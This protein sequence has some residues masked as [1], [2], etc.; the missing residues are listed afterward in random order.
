ME[1][2]TGMPTTKKLRLRYTDVANLNCTLGVAGITYW[3]C[4]NLF[5]PRVAIGGHQP[6][7]YDQYMSSYYSYATV[8]GSK[9]T[10]KFC[11]DATATS[12]PIQCM[13]Y[14]LDTAT[15]SLAA[16]GYTTWTAFREAKQTV[17]TINTN[18]SYAVCTS[19]FSHRK[20]IRSPVTDEDWK[21]SRTAGPSGLTQAN[22]QW[23]VIIQAMDLASTTAQVTADI[24]ID[25]MVLFSDR[26]PVAPS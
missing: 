16:Q 26:L 14:A 11:P 4:N 10:V 17:K 1:I 22:W 24:T 18:K 21:N 12:I 19:R 6:M 7:G 9:I 25:Y 2:T 20:M 3:A 8:L 23:A 15:T 13:V 5:D